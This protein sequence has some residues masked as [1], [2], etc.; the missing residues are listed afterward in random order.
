MLINVEWTNALQPQFNQY[1]Q[2]FDQERK[3]RI[4]IN[5][6]EKKIKK[7][8]FILSE[9]VSFRLV[10]SKI[11]ISWRLFTFYFSS[12]GNSLLVAC[13]I[14]SLRFDLNFKPP[15]KG[16]IVMCPVGTGR[17]TTQTSVIVILL[18]LLNAKIT[19]NDPK[20]AKRALT[21]RLNFKPKPKHT[22]I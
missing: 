18:K 12:M 22:L 16:L 1:W 8:D 14:N 4:K 9:L 5:K 3:F 10:L 20:E 7:L 19:R 6:P 2:C 13:Q 21:F 11:I 17:I 15:R